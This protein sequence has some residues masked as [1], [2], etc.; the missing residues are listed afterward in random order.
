MTATAMSDQKERVA[1]HGRSTTAISGAALLGGG[2][3]M[4]LFWIV[5]PVV[6]AVLTVGLVCFLIAL[7]GRRHSQ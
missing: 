7:I 3:G 2:A 6:W 4:V 1:R 5:G